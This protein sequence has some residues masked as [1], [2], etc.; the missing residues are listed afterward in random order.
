MNLTIFVGEQ[1]EEELEEEEKKR[2]SGER[3]GNRAARA[4][5][6][7][8]ISNT[9][10]PVEMMNRGRRGSERRCGECRSS[11]IKSLAFH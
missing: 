10:E 9:D 8:G 2:R 3:R 4:C 7:G 11:L 5:L 1:E 6:Q